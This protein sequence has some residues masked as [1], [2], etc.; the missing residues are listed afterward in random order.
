MMNSGSVSSLALGH[1]RV[2]SFTYL[3]YKRKLTE[4]VLETPAT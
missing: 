4:R 1:T 2:H 3:F